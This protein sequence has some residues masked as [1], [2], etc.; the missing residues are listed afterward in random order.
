[1]T[2]GAHRSASYWAAPDSTSPLIWGRL[3]GDCVRG[4]RKRRYIRGSQVG[5]VKEQAANSF[6]QTGWW[7]STGYTHRYIS[8]A[9]ALTCRYAS[10]CPPSWAG[11]N[12]RVNSLWDIES[13]SKSSVT[14]LILGWFLSDSA[15][16]VREKFN[17]ILVPCWNKYNYFHKVG[18]I[19]FSSSRL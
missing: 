1:M 9:V 12:P 13:F 4:D 5:E 17:M 11:K 14:G 2:S 8:L 10:R 3:K 16:C 15:C 19:M 6:R 7:P 18:N